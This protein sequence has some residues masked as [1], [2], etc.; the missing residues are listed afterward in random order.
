L[1]RLGRCG[2]LL[3]PSFCD[4]T[5]RYELYLSLNLLGL[6]QTIFD[7][8]YEREW[9]TEYYTNPDDFQAH[10]FK[11][12]TVGEGLNVYAKAEDGTTFRVSV[13]TTPN[14][15]GFHAD[16]RDHK[17]YMTLY[18]VVQTVVLYNKDDSGE[19]R[20]T[21]VEGSFQKYPVARKF[22]SEVLLSKEDGI[23]KESFEQ[24][25]EAVGLGERDC[26]YG[27]NVIVHAVGQTGENFLISVLKEQKMEAVRL[28]EAAMRIR[29]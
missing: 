27:E 2:T 3:I 12:S 13:A 4:V 7:A 23:T 28:A 5:I 1:A 21:I 17:L 14:V 22:A 20:K 26:G 24:Y 15:Q 19:A 25:D 8:G 16:P 11:H 9:F 29:G 18:H 10:H 6:V